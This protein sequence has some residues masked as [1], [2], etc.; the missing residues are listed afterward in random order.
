M[1]KSRLICIVIVLALCVALLAACNT[2]GFDVETLHVVLSNLEREMLATTVTPESY[3]LDCTV[4]TLDESGN[5]ATV[6]ILWTVEDDSG[7]INLQKGDDQTVT[8]VIPDVREED[9]SYKLRAELVD[10]NGKAYM[11]NGKPLTAVSNRVAPKTN[12][13]GTT[14][15]PG[16]DVGGGDT[17]HSGTLNDPYTV[18]DALAVI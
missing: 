14:P 8:I 16:G 18:A 6:Y 12:G 17:T 10:A 2:T 9:I 15:T 7:R 11:D 1:K 5:N 13:G 3:T 4:G